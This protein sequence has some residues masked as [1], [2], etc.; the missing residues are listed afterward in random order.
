MVT[1]LVTLIVKNVV[2][3]NV[4]KLAIYQWIG[5]LTLE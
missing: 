2:K 4:K 3:Q 1:I 5:Y